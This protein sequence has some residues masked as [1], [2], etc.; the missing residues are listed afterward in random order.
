MP[1]SPP[2]NLQHYQERSLLALMVCISVAGPLVTLGVYLREGISLLTWAGL[3]LTLMTYALLAIYAIGPRRLAAHALVY[4]LIAC[5]AVAI[6]AQGTVRSMASL[7]MLAAVVGAG[8]FLSRAHMMVCAGLAIVLLGLLNLAENSGLL[9]PPQYRTGW[10]VWITQSVVLVSL[11]ITVNLGRRRLIDAYRA[12]NLTLEHAREVEQL[13]RLSQS[14][15]QALFRS[16]PAA[17]LVQSLDTRDVIDVNEAFEDLFGHKREALAG[18]PP[19]RLWADDLLHSQFRRMIDGDGRV[20]NMLVQAVRHDGSVFDARLYAEV[21]D[22]GS[23]KLLIA[24]VFDVSA[25]T[26]SRHELEKSRERFSK[27]FNFSPLGMT[28]T[29]MR[30]GMFVE[31]N[32]ANERVLGW[33]QADF[34]GKTSVQA[35]VWVTLAD[36]QNYVDTLR[37]EGRLQA[38]ETRMRTKTGVIV[39]VRVWAEIIEIDGEPCALSFTLNV[40]DEKRREAMLLNV[41]EGVSGETGDAFFRSLTLHLADAIGADGVMVGEVDPQHQELTTLAMVWHGQLQPNVTHRLRET[42]CE[43]ALQQR[44]TLRIESPTPAHLP[45]VPPFRDSELQAF[46]GLPLRDAQGHPV[47]LL[48]AVWRQPPQQAPHL[49]ALLTIFASRCDAELLRSHSDREVRKLQETLE[50]RVADRTEQLQYLN[51]ELD[52]FAYS[53]SHDLKSPL[54]SIDGFTHLLREQMAER[55]LQDDRLLLERIEF[56]ILRMN[57]L[58]NDLLALARVSQGT[59]QRMNTNLSELAHDVLRQERHRDPTRQVSVTIE[60]DLLAD[61]DPRMAQIVLE[62]LMGNA[63]KYTRHTPDARITFTRAGRAEDGSPVFRVTDNGAGFDMTRSDRLFK[64]FNRLHASNEFEGTGIGLATVR[65]I[66]E[67][68]GGYIR[69]EGAVGQGARFEFAFGRDPAR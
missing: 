68:H 49:D 22:N 52:A 61:C 29:R 40:A 60:K 43:Q 12:Q 11:A 63:W 48:T 19:P 64:P 5:S 51:R 33:T 38:Y 23:E 8:V 30:D 16:T 28:I 7:V 17:C 59:L 27:A 31:V 45:L 53:V 58:I 36:R 57:R 26:A 9:P 4:M 10:A 66:L 14:R 35:N 24:V 15:F 44:G 54:R 32:P 21:A 47:G 46:L 25:E 65:R 6:A 55:L 39:P 42:L 67:R 62:N 34:A 1:S 41:A 69:G 37:R 50:Q 3:A 20:S 56:S 18:K 2:L 13:L